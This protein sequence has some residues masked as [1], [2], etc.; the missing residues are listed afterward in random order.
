ML[1]RV[2]TPPIRVEG[3]PVPEAVIEFMKREYGDV[4]VVD[5]DDE[6]VDVFETDWYKEVRRSMHGGDTLYIRRKNAGL[7]QAELAEKVGTSKSNIS[8]M[9]S[10]KRVIG[11]RMAKKLSAVFPENAP[12]DFM[13]EMDTSPR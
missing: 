12:E 10:G 5:D 6:L 13:K 8:L 2:K 7:T 1:V 9:E 3:D 11:R 4:E